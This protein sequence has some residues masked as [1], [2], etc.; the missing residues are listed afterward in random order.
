[1]R[2]ALSSSRNAET[3][4][5]GDERDEPD[6]NSY[7]KQQVLVRLDEDCSY[8]SFRNL[9]EE[10]LRQQMEERVTEET[11][12][13][14]GDHNVETARINVRWDQREEKV[15]WSRNVQCSHQGIECRARERKEHLEALLQEGGLDWLMFE[16]VCYDLLDDRALLQRIWIRSNSIDV[17]S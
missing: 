7:S 10:D 13:S 12:N 1:M 5:H 8:F 3:L 14:E 2:V 11:S 15:W 17:V 9:T 4:I 6:Q 16:L